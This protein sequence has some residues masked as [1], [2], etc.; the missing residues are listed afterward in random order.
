MRQKDWKDQLDLDKVK[1][2]PPFVE[3]DFGKIPTYYLSNGIEAAKVVS[4]FQGD[5]YNIGTALTY[6][7]RAGKKIYVNKSA[8]D[9]KEADI[10]KA[11]NHLNFELDR[12]KK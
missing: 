9:S 1:L 7:M 11:I 4:A 2:K 8:R 5:N 12:L 10:K 6:L 3:E